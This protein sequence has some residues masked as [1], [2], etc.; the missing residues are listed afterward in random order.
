MDNTIPK[1]QDRLDVLAR[2]KEYE[3]TGQFHLDVEN[4][5]PWTPLD[6]NNL[7]ILKKKLFNKIKA[8]IANFMGK[9]YFNSLMRKK[10]VIFAGV[11]GL[12]NLKDI[13]GGAMITC[14]HCH[15]FDNYAVYLGLKKFYTRRSFNLYKVVREGNYSYPGLVGFF[16]R[17]CHTL[18][19]NERENVNYR[20]TASTMKAIK[21][22]LERGEKI[23][24]YPEQGMWWNYRKPRPL[25]KGAFL[26][27]AKCNTPVVPC[28]LTMKDSDIIG[29][30]GFP[31]QEFTFNIL[32]ALYPDKD[33][34]VNENCELLKN[35]N[36]EVWK[37]LYEATY[38]LELSYGEEELTDADG[39]QENNDLSDEGEIG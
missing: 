4:D 36:Y 12:E 2:I 24:I 18:P 32:P 28:F 31:V 29:D 35:K 33:L 13:K 22:F 11:K 10:K 1:A 19:V 25:K 15:M 38:G 30:D 17:N 20:L 3:K 8:R 37:K 16:M 14:N 7:D 27:A 5:P 34:S 9:R 23:L 26:F 6:P 21:V 39:Y